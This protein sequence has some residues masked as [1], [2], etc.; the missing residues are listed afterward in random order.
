MS[1][2]DVEGDKNRTAGRDYYERYERHEHYYPAAGGH[3]GGGGEPPDGTGVPFTLQQLYAM[4]SEARRD[5]L[6][7]NLRKFVNKPV[8]ILIGLIALSLAS[9]IFMLGNADVLMGSPFMTAAPIVLI[10]LMSLHFNRSRYQLAAI[11]QAADEADQ[12]LH[13]IEMEIARRKFR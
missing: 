4:R 10:I 3:A 9:A 7:K 5:A 13:Q 12:Y 2:I 1:S 8:L 6:R 11:H